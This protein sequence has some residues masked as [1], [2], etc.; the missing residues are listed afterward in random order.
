VPRKP[1]Y[2]KIISID[3][4]ELLDSKVFTEA[5]GGSMP[6]LAIICEHALDCGFVDL[7][8]LYQDTPEIV[9][10]MCDRAH[11]ALRGLNK[12]AKREKGSRSTRGTDHAIR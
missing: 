3:N 10:R 7:V 12:L 4:Q 1:N 8:D 9:T 5:C 11:S 6:V 2:R